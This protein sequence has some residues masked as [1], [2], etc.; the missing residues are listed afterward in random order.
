MNLR[1][2]IFLIFIIFG[3]IS[4]A[5]LVF[6]FWYLFPAIKEASK[7]LTLTE[8]SLLS[9]NNEQSEQIKNTYEKMKQDYQKIGD[10]FSNPTTP[11]NLISFWEKIT[12]EEKLIMKISPITIKEYKYDLWKFLGFEITLSGY[13]VNIQRF[14]E[15]IENSKYFFEINS[16]VIKKDSTDQKLD[17]VTA[18]ILLKTYTNQ[19]EGQN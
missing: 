3:T 7:E 13:F 9:T 5:I 4:I 1:K 19:N 16:L 11:L 8:L 14:I 17:E 15:K 10:L 12:G 2:K 18:I 6:I